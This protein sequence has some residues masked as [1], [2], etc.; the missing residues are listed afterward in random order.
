MIEVFAKKYCGIWVCC[1]MLEFMKCFWD[2][3]KIL[4]YILCIFMETDNIAV[5]FQGHI[6]QPHTWW[7]IQCW[8]CVTFNC[9]PLQSSG[10]RPNFSIETLLDKYNTI[11]IYKQ[12]TTTNI[13]M[14]C[15]F[16]MLGT[17]QWSKCDNEICVINWF[18]KN[19]NWL[20]NKWKPIITQN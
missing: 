1:W 16:Y 7:T 18:L 5:L 15:I 13:T 2:C 19:S 17:P 11:I 8:S 12:K 4:R 6:T 10:L 20:K 14:Y 3:Y 9:V